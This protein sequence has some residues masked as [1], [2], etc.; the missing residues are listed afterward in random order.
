MQRDKA[1][2]SSKRK[3][4]RVAA[5]WQQIGWRIPRTYLQTGTAGSWIDNRVMPLPPSMAFL[6][7]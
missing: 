5:G 7:L 3:G 2:S 4:K 1:A 6:C